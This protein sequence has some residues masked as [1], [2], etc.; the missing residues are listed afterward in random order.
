[1]H[2]GHIR[3]RWP[4]LVRHRG[5]HLVAVR[6]LRVL[7][8]TMVGERL[9][10]R[11]RRRRRR[12]VVPERVGGK[13]GRGNA[14]HPATGRAGQFARFLAHPRGSRGRLGN[15]RCVHP[16]LV[17]QHVVRGSPL[18]LRQRY[19]CAA[20]E[21]T[22]PS[23]TCIGSGFTSGVSL[24]PVATICFTSP[25]AFDIRAGIGFT[26]ASGLKSR[27]ADGSFLGIGLKADAAAC[28]NW[29]RVAFGST[30]FPST[31]GL[32]LDAAPLPYLPIDWDVREDPMAAAG[33]GTGLRF[34]VSDFACGGCLGGPGSS[35]APPPLP[36][37]CLQKLMAEAAFGAAPYFGGRSDRSRRS[38]CSKLLFRWSNLFV[39]LCEPTCSRIGLLQIWRDCWFCRCRNAINFR[40]FSVR[41]LKSGTSG[42]GPAGLPARPLPCPVSACCSSCWSGGRAFGRSIVF[43]RFMRSFLLAYLFNGRPPGSSFFCTVLITSEPDVAGCSTGVILFR[44][45]ICSAVFFGSSPGLCFVRLESASSSELEPSLNEYF[46]TSA[47]CATVCVG[48]LKG[49]PSGTG[50]FTVLCR[51]MG[52]EPAAGTGSTSLS[53]AVCTFC[54]S[55]GTNWLGR[56]IAKGGAAGV[57]TVPSDC[58]FCSRYALSGA[59]D[60]STAAAVRCSADCSLLSIITISSMNLLASASSSRLTPTVWRLLRFVR[61]LAPNL[62]LP[63]FTERV[64]HASNPDASSPCR[65]LTPATVTHQ[66]TTRTEVSYLVRLLQTLLQPGDQRQQGPTLLR[67]E[68]HHLRLTTG[69]RAILKRHLQAL[70]CGSHLTQQARQPAGMALALQ[71]GCDDGDDVGT[72]CRNGVAERG[73]EK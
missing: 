23:W 63:A 47:R 46:F 48:F 26:T 22:S 58:C 45:T 72:R 57:S 55:F 33:A 31:T 73:G 59:T 69:T 21:R 5:L 32:L 16:R 28:E 20:S 41:G 50:C 42:A 12:F 7:Q 37:A 64:W 35:T 51:S 56:F 2:A 71:I 43:A 36:S 60:A 38:P 25:V 70:Q 27:F 14:G 3:Q 10:R 13:L 4:L 8:R 6:F 44:S 65:Q 62:A 17:V 1:M 52:F 49:E 24:N 54:I 68:S 34:G 53:S 19:P 39:Q 30:S 18:Q 67:I 9:L 40:S 15:A 11:R 66:L 61:R 29:L